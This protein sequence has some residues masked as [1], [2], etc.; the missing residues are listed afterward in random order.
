MPRL[1]TAG[2]AS[3]DTYVGIVAACSPVQTDPIL[4]NDQSNTGD[5][6]ST[7]LL[8]VF[9]NQTLHGGNAFV[10]VFMPFKFDVSI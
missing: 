5:D 4:Q 2:N 1:H 10:G 9:E 3:A 7:R 8:C 6:E